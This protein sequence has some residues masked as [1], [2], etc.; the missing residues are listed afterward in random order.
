MN[1]LSSRLRY[2][3][4][5]CAV[6]ALMATPSAADPTVGLGL[7]FSFGG[8]G[9]DTGIGLRVFSDNRREKAVGSVGVDYMFGSQR[10]RGTLGAAYLDRNGYI[11]V[12]LG[13][14]L[15]DGAIDFG[16]GVGGVKTKSDDDDGEMTYPF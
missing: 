6:P 4:M 16:V 1:R 9:V 15:G 3:A 8:G 2:F 5:T 12:D 14:G 10:W 13:I 7:T 11:G